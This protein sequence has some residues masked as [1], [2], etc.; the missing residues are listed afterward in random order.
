MNNQTHFKPIIFRDA[1]ARD[2]IYSIPQRS[3]HSFHYIP[4]IKFTGNSVIIVP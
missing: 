2:S 1:T 4:S 3:F